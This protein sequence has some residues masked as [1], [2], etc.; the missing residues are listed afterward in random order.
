MLNDNLRTAVLCFSYN[1]N[2]FQLNLFVV[3]GKQRNE[4]IRLKITLRV[5]KVGDYYFSPPM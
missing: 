2:V 3:V 5:I 4:N 1:G